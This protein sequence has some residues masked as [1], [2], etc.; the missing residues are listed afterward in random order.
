[1]CES[2]GAVGLYKGYI[3]GNTI[4]WDAT[5]GLPDARVGLVDGKLT[6]VYPSVPTSITTSYNRGSWLS[7]CGP[8]S[9]GGSGTTTGSAMFWVASDLGCGPITV[10]CNSVSKT[11]TGF[12]GSSPACGVTNSANFTFSPGTYSFSASCSGKTWSGNITVTSNECSKL[13]LTN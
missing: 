10:Q 6:F 2:R 3:T 8:L 5:Y 9:I 7:R 13:Q 12:Y 1:M 4:E 11:I